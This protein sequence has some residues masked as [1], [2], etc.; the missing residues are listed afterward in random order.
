MTLAYKVFIM[1][2]QC[3]KFRK[4]I[5]Y[6]TLEFAGELHKRFYVFLGRNWY[7]D[8]KETLKS[9]RLIHQFSFRSEIVFSIDLQ[10]YKIPITVVYQFL[11]FLDYNWRNMEDKDKV[12]S[13]VIVDY[14]NKVYV[15]H[16]D[17]K[18][19]VV[20]LVSPLHLDLLET[21]CIGHHP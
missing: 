18:R 14:F 21:L 8:I 13:R 11:L 6:C 17:L 3:R 4:E 7:F 1:S 15:L 9:L 19:I 10:D 20:D 16:L 5:T 2:T 12:T